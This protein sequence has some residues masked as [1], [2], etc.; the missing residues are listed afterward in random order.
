MP[1]F[2]RQRGP[3]SFEVTIRSGREREFKNVKTKADAQ[4][5]CRIIAEQERQGLDVV[6]I[7]RGHQQATLSVWRRLRDELPEFIATMTA[8]GDW[9]GSTPINYARRL[10]TFVYDFPLA[11]GRKLGDLPVDQVTAQQI[12]AVLDI[13]RARQAD[14]SPGKSLAVQYQIR[15]PLVAYYRELRTKKGFIGLNPAEN[16]KAYMSKPPSKRARQG[17]TDYFRQEEAPALFQTCEALWP[18]RLAFIGV[19]VLAGLRY[20]EAAALEV[21]DLDF[22]HELIH[23]RR[24]FSDKTGAVKDVKDHEDRFVPMGALS[25]RLAGWLTD[26]LERVKLEGQVQR[27]SLGQR[28]LVFPNTKGRITYHSTFLEHI[29]QPLLAKAGLAYRKPHAM[30]H[31]FGTWC[32]E[33]NPSTGVPL[34]PIHQLRDWMGHA[35]V[36]ETERYL[37]AQRARAGRSVDILKGLLP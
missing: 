4:G 6:A 28:R 1:A 27:W 35:S 5:L 25:P 19:S 11:D 22:R 36:E 16:L 8:R 34:V 7:A 26:H 18:D 2:F 33:G 9:T 37:H 24:S 12:G 15:S 32:A 13:I 31:T 29:W 20:G 23:V 14:G 10:K 17:K 3:H 30:R 21:G